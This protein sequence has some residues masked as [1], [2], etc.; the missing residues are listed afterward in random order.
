[1][2]DLALGFG[3]FGRRRAGVR[4]RLVLRSRNAPICRTESRSWR[5]CGSGRDGGRRGPGDTAALAAA[6]SRF[7]TRQQQT[8]RTSPW[9]SERPSRT[10]AVCFL[11]TVEIS[12]KLAVS[13][14]S[15]TAEIVLHP[16]SF[17][18][19]RL[20]FRLSSIDRKSVV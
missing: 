15:S 12:R 2:G 6:W 3:E 7:P 14:S 4:D 16:V 18:D 17:L 1:M 20:L 5:L 19:R 11:P 8:V 9:S 13:V 10:V